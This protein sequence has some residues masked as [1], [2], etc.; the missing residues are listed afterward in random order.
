MGH[1]KPE[2]AVR[3]RLITLVGKVCVSNNTRSGIYVQRVI[4]RSF[5]PIQQFSEL[6]LAAMDLMDVLKDLPYEAKRLLTQLTEGKLKIEFEHVGL[7]PLRRTLNQ[8]TNRLV[9]A[10]ILA[11]FIVGSS[12]IVLS[13][14]PP[15]V[16]NMPIIGLAGYIVSGIFALWLVI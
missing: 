8:I 5:N 12:L 9:M 11:S 3:R 16:A 4:R 1:D 13:G 15:L 10:V 2:D 6:Q 7:D 14:L